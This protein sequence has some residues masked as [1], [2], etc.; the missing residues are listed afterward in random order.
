VF[1]LQRMSHGET[2]VYAEKVN[3]AMYKALVLLANRYEEP[4]HENV[5]HPN[6]HKLLDIRDKFFTWEDNPSRTNLFKA[7]FR[8]GIH[9]YEDPYYGR[10]L[11]WLV[12]M[13]VNSDWVTRACDYPNESWNEP[14]P[15]GGGYLIKDE[16]LKQPIFRKRMKILEED[17]G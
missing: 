3:R 11:D 6:S 5:L 10:R 7:V 9:K 2:R 4:T 14:A 8:V 16:T 13:I 15:Y 17:D 12:E 1:L